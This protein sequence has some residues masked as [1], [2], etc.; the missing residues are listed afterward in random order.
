MRNRPRMKSS[1]QLLAIVLLLTTRFSPIARAAD[2]P[3]ARVLEGDLPGLD[4]EVAKILRQVVGEAGY[5][6]DSVSADGLC[7]AGTFAKAP[8]NL[9]VIP[10]GRVLPTASIRVVEDYLNAG[11]QM[12]VCGLPLW[13]EGV[14]KVAGRWTTQHDR[15]A[16]LAATQP[17]QLLVDFAKEDLSRW[18]RS[19]NLERPPATYEATPAETGQGLHV[20]VPELNGWDTLGREVTA[21]FSEGD[22][23]TCFRAKGDNRTKNLMIEWQEKDGSRWIATVELTES[24]RRYALPPEAFQAWEPRAGRG[25]KGDR[26][27]VGNA[28]RLVLGVAYSHMAIQSSRQEYWIADIGTAPNPLPDAP[29]AVEVPHLE[30]LCPGYQFFPITGPV[31]IG[32]P[33]GTGA[34][35]Q[36]TVAAPTGVMGVHPRPGP[37]GFDKSKPWL[38]RVI[39]EARGEQGEYRGAV[40]TLSIPLLDGKPGGAWAAFTPVDLAFYREAGVARSI[41]KVARDLRRG[42]FLYEAGA[43]YYTAL[44]G[45]PIRCGAEIVNLSSEPVTDCTVRLTVTATGESQPAFERTWPLTVAPRSIMRVA[46]DWTPASWP[47]QGY[48]VSTDLLENQVRLDRVTHALHCWNPKAQP[49][50]VEARDGG[51]WLEGRPWKVHGVNYMPSSGVGLANGN[52]FEFWLGAAAYDPEIVRRDLE[53]IRAMNMNAVSVFLHHQSLGAQNLLDLLR[54]CDELG[55]RVNLSLRPGTPLD[56][57]WSQVR[58]MIESLRLAENDTIFAY[59]LAWEPS[60]YDHQSQKRYAPAWQT[61]LEKRYSGIEHAER[62]WGVPAPREGGQLSIPSD[63]Q[64]ATDGPWRKMVADYRGFLDD[65]LAG[66]YAEARRLVRSID[67]HHAVSFRMQLAGDPTYSINPLPYDFYGLRESVDVWEPEAYGRIGDWERVKPGCFTAA[68]ARLCDSRKPVLWAEMGVSVWDRKTLAPAEG[69]LRFQAAFYRDFYR[70]MMESGSDGVFAWWYPGG[71]RVNEQSDFGIIN[72]DGTDRPV[73]K[74]IRDLGPQFLSAAKP[75]SPD[76]RIPVDRD[77]DARGLVGTYKAAENDYWHALAQGH[78]PGLRWERLPTTASL[79]L[80][81][82]QVIGTHNSYHQRG[83]DSLLALIRQ[84]DPALAKGLDYGHPPLAEQLSRGIRQIELDC[85]ADPQG[86]LFAHPR[87]PKAAAAAG[88]PPVPDRDPNAALQHPGFKVMHVQ[89]IDYFS[90]VLTFVQGLQQVRD[91]SAQH[92]DHFPIFILIELKDDLPSP[93]L[94]P[95]VPIGTNELAALEGEILSVFR[96]DEILTPDDVRGKEPTLPEALRKHGWPTLA[97]ARGKV[98]FG[99]DNGGSIRDLYLQG[100]PALQGRLLFVNVP[101]DNPAAAWMEENDPVAGFAKIQEWVKAG[102]LVRTRADAD[103]LEARRNDTQRRDRAFASGAQFIST[104]Y[105]EPNPAFSN[106]F[107]Q[108]GEGVDVRNNPVSDK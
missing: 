76:V 75:A 95:P 98:M 21:P 38:R 2:T 24:W 17:R 43:N 103:T 5:E 22:T 6:T 64:L 100:H 54:L 92:P 39:L 77:A 14:A 63:T 32:Q 26:I 8:C 108:F 81:Q 89:D 40:A 9:L 105:P 52:L 27:Q 41:Q 78:R 93:E 31:R 12:I 90:S 86:G 87:G 3:R 102:F 51:F 79:R 101:P 37:A 58:E 28:Q 67:P 60:H 91:W 99:L 66:P 46:Q 7:D 53:R 82:V 106:Y 96:Q 88:L 84:K 73:T 55:L 13:E 74:V 16:L 71:Y 50:F 57:H 104:D 20:I 33:G 10:N 19:S 83:H 23:L 107:V 94:T 30:G 85:F 65:Y 56:F 15:D 35:A 18:R 48:A 1:F 4:Q 80:N 70:M 69:Q 68:Y 49:K 62:A 47:S 61:W 59:D 34:D 45:Q 11:G 36:A 97:E 44:T 42:L 72:P 25:G 29:P